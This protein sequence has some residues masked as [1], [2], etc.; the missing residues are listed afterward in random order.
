MAA[1][2]GLISAPLAHFFVGFFQ[3]MFAG[4]P[5][6]ARTNLLQILAMQLVQSP[7]T[8]LVY[9]A[10]MAV[11]NGARTANQVRATVRAGFGNVL[12]SMWIS[13]PLAIAVAQKFLPQETWVVWFN[14]VSF[15]IGV[16][17]PPSRRSVREPRV[18][19]RV[20]LDR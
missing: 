7:I 18:A 4:R 8:A 10:S 11:I 2:G 12:K 19:K 6:S 3:R 16:S 5:P 1:Y 13:S 17:S 9:L 15:V 14:V 20:E